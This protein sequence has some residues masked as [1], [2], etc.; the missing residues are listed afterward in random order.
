MS[1]FEFGRKWLLA[2]CVGLSVLGL[3]LLFAPAGL[4]DAAFESGI[5]RVF[6]PEGAVAAEAKMFQRWVYA[7][8]GATVFGWG[9]CL[10]FVVH[11]GFRTRS[12]W[13]WSCVFWGIVC[14]YVPD[15]LLSA[16]YGVWFNVGLNT[17]LL[18][19]VLVP[20]S[21]TRAFMKDAAN[22]GQAS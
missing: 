20:L 2:T 18:I 16:F 19:L 9:I 12:R 1:R 5:D 6:W 13:A 11:F 10:A 22:P 14:W 15:S 7:V 21:F 17:A 4:I 3:G 8:L